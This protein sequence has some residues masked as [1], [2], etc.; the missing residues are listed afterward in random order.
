[1]SAFRLVVE[2]GR[3]KGRFLRL[4]PNQSATVGREAKNDLAIQDP[5]ASR[6]H[7]RIEGKLG[8]FVLLDLQSSNGTFVNGER[9][10]RTTLKVGDRISIG[11]TLVCLLPETDEERGAR[12]GPLSG[13]ELGGYRIGHVL[14]RGGMGTV[15]EAVQVT[16]ERKVALK[17]LAPELSGA[18][19]FVARFEAEARAAGRLNHANLVGVYDVADLEG[20]RV[21]SM[22]LMSGGS[23]EDL[24]RREG[25]LSLAATLP[26]L[27][28]AAR[29]LEYASKQGL[30]HRDVK[31]ANLM[32]GGDG[33]VKLCDL[34]LAIFTSRQHDVSGS[35]HYIAPEQ[36]RG[37]DIDGRADLYALGASWLELLSGETLYQGASAG[38]IAR[39][40]IEAPLPDLAARL[41]E[42]PADALEL[43]SR[44]LAKDPAERYPSAR[45][46]QADLALLARRHADSALADRL[47]RQAT[48]APLLANE[49]PAPPALPPAELARRLAP[50]LGLLVLALLLGGGIW[51]GLSQA[52]AAAAERRAAAAQRLSELEALREEEPAKAEAGVGDLIASLRAEGYPDLAERAEALELAMQ[53]ARAGEVQA[54]RERSAGLKLQAIAALAEGQTGPSQ[55][56]SVD[57]AA[58]R[59]RVEEALRLIGELVESYP[60]TAAALEGQRLRGPLVEALERFETA[61]RERRAKVD[62]AKLALD[63]LRAEVAGLLR[64]PKRGD[65]ARALAACRAYLDAH[66]AVETKAG[67][68][69]LRE[70][71]VNA[72]KGVAAAIQRAR[73]MV[74][75][76]SWDEAREALQPLG[77]PL[78]LPELEREVREAEDEIEEALRA[79]RADRE[80]RERR[81]AEALVAGAWREAKPQLEAR[82]FGSAALPL[83]DVLPRIEL[84]DVRRL[85]QLRA[86]RLEA[87]QR[88]LARL[89]EHLQ[90]QQGKPRAP[91]L[92]LELE[93]AGKVLRAH[94]SAGDAL[95]RILTFAVTEQILRDVHITALSADDLLALTTPLA[96]SGRH[97]L[98]LACL[99]YELGQGM[100]AEQLLLEA[101]GQSPAFADE[102]QGLRVLAGAGQ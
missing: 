66:G 16:L 65:Y 27:F 49:P 100:R 80:Q 75:R 56:P 42:L 101:G 62:A 64:A 11:D 10:T 57:E 94:A 81:A 25:K 82:R 59:G 90:P 98:D 78:G 85:A 32:L 77:G 54:E 70:V 36:A 67:R 86:G 3:S 19:E 34:G 22:E 23:L 37:E 93:V 74:L 55:D 58:Q 46:L 29:A 17:A 51:F 53:E 50:A 15:Y 84:A 96:K 61:A 12:R 39:Q 30:V 33:T 13:Q 38:E 72:R 20:Q 9:L 79:S 88:V 6:Q 71:E 47:E 95:S 44:L 48:A 68:A 24:L 45:E 4:K 60:S 28:D 2:R 43:L 92:W 83:R 91:L 40:Q 73:S 99:A 69:L 97:K 31:P 8:E 21:I 52:R 26:L 76:E 7:L 18:P 102:I 14:G 89:F 87:A 35:P 1:M 63:S 5:Q 41:P